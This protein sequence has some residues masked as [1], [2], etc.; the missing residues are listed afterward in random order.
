MEDYKTPD[1]KCFPSEGVKSFGSERNMLQ[2]KKKSPPKYC[3]SSIYVHF[4]S[5]DLTY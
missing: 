2:K 3:K 1:F 5:Y 4:A